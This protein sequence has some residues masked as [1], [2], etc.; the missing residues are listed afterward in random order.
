MQPQYFGGALAS[1][2]LLEQQGPAR[3]L[4]AIPASQPQAK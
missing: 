2:A 1:P 4:V 3:T